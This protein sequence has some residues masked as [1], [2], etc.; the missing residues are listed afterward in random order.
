MSRR[1]APLLALLLVLAVAAAATAAPVVRTPGYRGITTPIATQA[2][3]APAPSTLGSGA[4]P[5]ILVDDAGTAHVVW[6]EDRPGAPD[7]TVYCRVPRGAAGC[8]I[9]HDLTPPGGDEY[10]DDVSGP[11]VTAVNDQVVV[12]SHR[13]PQTVTRP[14]GTTGSGVV[15]MWTSDDGGDS[16]NTAAMVAS[17]RGAN[18]A[19]AGDVAGGAVAFGP[20]GNPSIAFGTGVVTGGVS[21]TTVRAGT[22]TPVGAA[23][24][25]GDYAW[26]RLA[27][28][29]GTPAVVYGDLSGNAHMRRWTGQGDPNDGAT[30]SPQAALGGFNPDITVAGGRP[31]VATASSLL[32]GEITVRDLSGAAAPA[33]VNPGARSGD[34]RV[35]GLPDGRVVVTWSG[36]PD[37]R[38]AGGTWVRTLGAGGRPEAPAAMIGPSTGFQRMAA[39]ADGGGM[40]VGEEAGAIVM[41]GFGSPAPTG[42]PG[43]GGRPGGGALPA[44]AAEEC[45]RIRFGAVEALLQDGCFLNAATGRAKVSSGAVRLNG[46]EIVPDAGVQIIVNARTRTID[47]TG[48]VSV[49]LRAPGVPEILLYRGRLNLRLG[50]ARAGTQLFG[51][52]TG[53]FRTDV[54]GFPVRGDVDVRLTTNGVRIPINLALPAAFGGVTGATTLRA[55]NARGLVVESLKFRADGIPLG[56]ATMRRLHVQYKASGGTSVGD[57]LRPPTSGASA[58]PDEWAGVFELQLPPP[59]TGP[60]L[61]GSVRFSGG[62]FRAAT[63]NIDLP[64]PGIVLFPGV[65][66]TALGGG[67]ALSPT[68]IDAAMRVS[69]I[70][71]GGAGLVNLDGRVS[72]RF[73]APFRLTGTARTSTAGVTLGTG[74]FTI[75]SD[76]YVG[77]RLDVGPEVGPLAVRTR[78]SG[79]ADGPRREFSLSGRGEVCVKGACVDGGGAVVSTRGVAV[80]LPAPAVPRGGGYRWGA[81]PLSADLWLVSCDMGDYE[82]PDLRP[83]ERAAHQ[84]GAEAAATISGRPA[85]ATFR[86]AGA[87]GVPDVDL[88][89]PT[90]EPVAPQV[91]YPDADT[92]RRYLAVTAPAPGRWTVR[93]RPGSPA[94]TELAVARQ[95]APARVARARVTGAGHRPRT[96]TYRAVIGDDQSIVFAERGRAGTRVIGTARP[97][98]H[99]LRFTPGPGAGGRREIVA[100]IAQGG[101]VRVEPVVARYTAPPPRRVGKATGLR[102]SRAGGRAVARWRVPPGAVVQRVTLTVSDGRALVRQV[103]LRVRRAQIAGLTR[104]DRV[105]V[106][107]VGVARDGRTGRPAR[108]TLR[109]R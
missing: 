15:Y 43:L 66:I 61:C 34:A 78:I 93:P 83:G 17:G 77:L 52:A 48:T 8:A 45:Q 1:L 107:V 3:V 100:L 35:A 62:A 57:C 95:V 94:I 46:L 99:R 9:R 64:P 49:R 51:F 85:S 10:A 86:V 4:R 36:T 105:T 73:G 81:S 56:V 20:A 75:S 39:T 106:R 102:L 32:G 53:I 13:Y 55:D 11:A 23:I 2:A 37:A 24:A 82:V 96:L 26:A 103:G 7:A 16:F 12:L 60:A 5:D 108:A 70:P 101:L 72:A 109:L 47:T 50:A 30:W 41:S 68:Q 69:V 21:V 80:C 92:G 42:R 65:S 25:T 98:A 58:G 14:D 90:G 104:G 74:T 22:Y 59:G 38:G 6:T 33:V 44:D 91:V 29:D 31:V 87:G 89:G 84:A 18:T 63:F 40:V 28:V 76:G 79:F 88:I 54:L 27:V 19:V 97:G 67:L 71:A